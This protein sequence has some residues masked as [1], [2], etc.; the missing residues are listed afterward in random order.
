[1]DSLTVS[2]SAL[3]VSILS[4]LI[5]VYRAG[6]DRRIQFEQRRGE[7]KTRLTFWGVDI[8]SLIEGLKNP[9]SIDTIPVMQKLLSVANALVDIREQIQRL[10]V[11]VW[12]PV[13]LF[14]VNFQKIRNDTA[15][16]EPL[17]DE[18]RRETKNRNFAKVNEIANGIIHRL[19]GQK[20]SA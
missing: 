9:P 15:D 12:L 19:T 11:P 17:I 16:L 4:L 6:V 13:S 18:L 1:M 20:E 3:G 8:L 2:I 5:S 14:A 7:I 10:S